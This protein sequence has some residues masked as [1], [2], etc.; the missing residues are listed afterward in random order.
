[1]RKVARIAAG[2]IQTQIEVDHRFGPE[3]GR[4]G[5]LTLR[6][7]PLGL[8]PSTLSVGAAP[9][10]PGRLTGA[11][12]VFDDGVG[13]DPAIQRTDHYG[14]QI[15]SD[16]AETLGGQLFVDSTPGGGCSVT[17]VFPNGPSLPRASQ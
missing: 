15:M 2:M 6:S 7:S 13:F 1:M 12:T 10:H 4:S 3:S 11:T 8:W 5:M 9:P 16:R 14:I 17:L